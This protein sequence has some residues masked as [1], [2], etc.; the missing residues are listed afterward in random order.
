MV[1]TAA[2]YLRLIV[3]QDAPISVDSLVHTLLPNEFG[4]IGCH[5]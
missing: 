2:R 4:A 3:H 1:V 5:S